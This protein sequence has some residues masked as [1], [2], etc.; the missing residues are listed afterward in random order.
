M[1]EVLSFVALFTSISSFIMSLVN[2]VRL[3]KCSIKTNDKVIDLEIK[4][5]GS[6]VAPL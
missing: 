3:S 2:H 4:S 5:K 6:S 1:V